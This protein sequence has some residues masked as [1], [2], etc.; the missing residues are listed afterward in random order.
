MGS[1]LNKETQ[2]ELWT[3]PI[4]HGNL[5]HNTE[6]RIWITSEASITQAV[7]AAKKF[8]VQV[9]FKDYQ[10]SMI[11]SAVSELARN[12][13][14]YAR[15][16]E[17]VLRRVSQSYATGIEIIAQDEGPGI[18]NPEEAMQ[19][20]YSSSGTL[21]L[22]LPGVK[23]LMDEFDLKTEVERGTVITVRKWL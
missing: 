12:I 22:G 2:A 1:W 13:E 9:G 10:A 19:D 3:K 14:K 4:P 17:I 23:R 7:L 5:M 16:G 15:R 20:H 8:S 18:A 6:T 11:A 21:G